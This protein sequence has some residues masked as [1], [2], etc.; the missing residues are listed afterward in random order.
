MDVVDA[1]LRLSA[2]RALL[3]AIP[4]EVRLI[5]VSLDGSL[6]RLTVLAA[7]PLGDEAV[8]GL[9]AAATEIVA[10]F[11]N[12]R[13]EEHL[14]VTR[15]PLPMEDVLTE[16]WVYQRAEPQRIE[17]DR[18]DVW[19][20]GSATCVIAVGSHGDPLDLGENEVESLIEKLQAA[21]VQERA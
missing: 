11:P 5:K 19:H 6:I 8:D 21:L 10:D 17:Q 14:L 4:P 1:P 13:I 20:D 3:G 2:Q 15:D 7:E 16:G 12:C 18:L 9:S